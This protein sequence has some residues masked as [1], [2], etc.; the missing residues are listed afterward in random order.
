MPD[1]WSEEEDFR[2]SRIRSA[3][4]MALVHEDG[5]G[6]VVAQQQQC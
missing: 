2:M 5:S 3:C 1:P 6:G 4:L